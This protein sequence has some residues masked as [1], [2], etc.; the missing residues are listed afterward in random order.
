MPSVR[1]DLLL[2]ILFEITGGGSP[3]DG[4]N[5]QG[6]RRK[7]QRDARDKPRLARIHFRG[8]AAQITD[9]QRKRFE[10]GPVEGKVRAFENDIGVLQP[11]DDALRH[12]LGLPAHADNIA[13]FRR[14]PVID[15]R[16]G[17]SGGN[18]C[19][20]FAHMAQPLKVMQGLCPSQIRRL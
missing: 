9:L 1:Q 16:T 7:S 12:D 17:M 19:S 20:G 4:G 18:I 8:K 10:E 15:Q 3:L 2:Q 6:E 5:R 14:H 13:A 11:G